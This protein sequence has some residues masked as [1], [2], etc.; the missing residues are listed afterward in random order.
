MKK[1]QNHTIINNAAY[2]AH[3]E[4]LQTFKNMIQYDHN[5]LVNYE[6]VIRSTEGETRKNEY[7]YFIHLCEQSADHLKGM[8][9]LLL[10]SHIINNKQYDIYNARINRNI[11]FYY[12]VIG[13]E[14]GL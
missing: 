8:L 2:V 4:L 11:K 5:L 13:L 9:S 1:N 6:N 3:D 10:Q 12:D 14:L 7:N